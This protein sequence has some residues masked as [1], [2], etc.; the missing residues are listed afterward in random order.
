MTSGLERVE[1]TNGFVY[2]RHDYA[3]FWRRT[4]ALAFDL[5]IIHASY[6]ALAWTWYVLAP[7][8]WATLEAY[9]FIF[10]FTIVAG[11]LYMFALRLTDGGTLGYRLL[12]IRYAYIYDAR[13]DL[14]TR[15]ARAAWAVALLCT[16]SLDHL[17]ILF[18][19]HRQTW[20]DK[21]SGFYVVKRGAQPLARVAIRRRL[22][23]F[24]NYTF[25]VF[26]PVVAT[27]TGGALPPHD[28][29]SSSVGK[30]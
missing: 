30:T 13:P 14:T 7:P 21:V 5:L 16:F 28:Q 20:H 24:M 25:A 12:R 23:F 3:G 17:W 2:A 27:S 1:S 8:A 18:D 19:E 22:I 29:A 10:L 11:L 6:F 9:G 26:E 15:I 4:A